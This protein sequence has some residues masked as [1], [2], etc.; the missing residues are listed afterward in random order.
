[1][2]QAKEE[3]RKTFRDHKIIA[4]ESRS[5][6]VGKPGTSKSSF[7]VTWSPG[8]VLLY[9]EIGNI[10]LISAEF[11]SYESAKKWLGSCKP[12][13]FENTI[14]HETPKN[15]DYFFEACRF[16]GKQPHYK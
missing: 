4:S 13:E 11:S 7:S 14:A 12:E 6:Y 8:S 9:G 5:W 2:N 16:W 10:T 1:M 3:I 15:L